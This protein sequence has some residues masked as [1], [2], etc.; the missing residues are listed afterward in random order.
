MEEFN[1]RLNNFLRDQYDTFITA[2]NNHLEDLMAERIEFEDFEDIA[3][4]FN[5][6]FPSIILIEQV[7]S[8]QLQVDNNLMGEITGYIVNRLYRR[9]RNI[10]I[11]VITDDLQE[12]ITIPNSIT[13][14]YFR[15][16][17]VYNEYLRCLN[18]PYPILPMLADVEP[19]EEFD[20]TNEEWED[21]QNMVDEGETIQQLQILLQN[22]PFAD[23][24]TFLEMRN[25]GYIPIYGFGYK[26]KQKRTSL[27][28]STMKRAKIRSIN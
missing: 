5:Q 22:F 14:Y 4:S 7:V 13:Q 8:Q 9:Y 10:T 20:F 18:Y 17:Y 11:E 26:R 23:F 24:N 2:I 21:L 15:R 16:I 12:E 27:S 1:E 6:A 3:A 28:A 25:V 19:A